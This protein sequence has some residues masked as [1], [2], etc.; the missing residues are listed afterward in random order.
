MCVYMCVYMCI[1]VFKCTTCLL[2]VVEPDKLQ[3]TLYTY[4][5]VLARDPES[6]SLELGSRILRKGTNRTLMGTNRTL[7]IPVGQRLTARQ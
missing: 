2:Y 6:W 4:I 5:M 7:I 1:C 3:W